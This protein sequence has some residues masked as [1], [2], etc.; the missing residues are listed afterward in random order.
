MLIN[1]NGTESDIP[2]N[3][4]LQGLILS[5]QLPGALLILE[6][7]GEIIKR[8]KWDNIMLVRGDSLEIIQVIGGG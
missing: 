8:E 2:E 7:N 3:A 6:L 5:R 4:T 1:I